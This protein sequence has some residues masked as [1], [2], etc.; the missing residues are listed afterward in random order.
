M[1]DNNRNVQKILIVDDTAVIRDLLRDIL[2]SEGY[3]VRCAEDGVVALD[4]L[5]DDEFDLVFCDIH[6]PRKNGLQTLEESR[7]VNPNLIWVMTDSLPDHLA[8]TAQQRGAITCISKPFD[9]EEVR[10][11][12]D[13]AETLYSDVN[14]APEISVSREKN[15]AT[16]S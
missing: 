12:L 11:C 2:V 14:N 15:K 1:I 4:M 3:E 16:R 5:S 8:V 7:E 9:I 10:E 6:M 13:R